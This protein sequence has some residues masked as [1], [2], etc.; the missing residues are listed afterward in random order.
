MLVV[1]TDFSAIPY[2]DS[3]L[4]F[5]IFDFEFV[6][7]GTLFVGI[8]L[9]RDQRQIPSEDLHL[10]QSRLGGRHYQCRTTLNRILNIKLFK[11]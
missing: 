7:F 3:V 11:L 6:T 2:S 10:L 9:G 1:P 5:V 4:S 8:L